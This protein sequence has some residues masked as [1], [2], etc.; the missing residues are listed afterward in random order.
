MEKNEGQYPL[1]QLPSDMRNQIMISM[2]EST[3]RESNTVQEAV[4]EFNRLTLVNSF[5][6]SQESVNI[7]LDTLRK[8]FP[9][10]EV[11]MARALKNDYA[12][13][14]LARIQP[15]LKSFRTKY[16]NQKELFA[17]T[18]FIKKNQIELLRQWLNQGYDPNAI[19][20]EGLLLFIAIRE[21]NL[22]AIKLLIAYGADVN[23]TEREFYYDSF[24]ITP[25]QL[26]QREINAH[27]YDPIAVEQL[28]EID[29]Y[30]RA[31]GGY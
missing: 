17:V 18:T 3:A 4:N 30:L 8:K 28:N 12:R 11:R 16:V 5:F 15:E 20:T 10:Q 31:Q 21:H 1:D 25:L 29:D 9:G 2:I 23:A 19:A 26:V 22:E 6:R 7:F 24:A 14:W 27:T 13:Q